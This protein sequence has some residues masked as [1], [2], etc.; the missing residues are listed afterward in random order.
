MPN[1]NFLENIGKASVI[2]GAIILGFG[3]LYKQVGG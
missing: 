1:S 2:A 3:W